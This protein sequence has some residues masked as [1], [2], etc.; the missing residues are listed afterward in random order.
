[1]SKGTRFLAWGLGGLLLAGIAFGLLQPAEPEPEFPGGVLG[2]SHHTLAQWI[3]LAT[4]GATP[5][6][7]T[8]EAEVAV[9]AA[10]TNA[11]PTLLK[12]TRY[13]P[14]P[15]KKFCYGI[16]SPLPLPEQIRQSLWRPMAQEMVLEY[17]ADTGFRL[18][19]SNAVPAIAELARLGADPL[20]TQVA[21]RA[22]HALGR[23]GPLAI[24]ELLRIIN[25]PNA[26]THAQAIQELAQFAADV[27]SIVP[28][29]LAFAQDPKADLSYPAVFMLRKIAVNPDAAVPA[30]AVALGSSDPL[31]RAAAADSLAHFGPEASQAVP[32][33]QF[34][35]LDKTCRVRESATNALRRIA[36]EA[37]PHAPMQ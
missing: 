19:N 36:P 3:D 1:M 16:L 14:N 9:R 31:T 37:L 17:W 26:R 35:L 24:P 21:A 5:R 15:L 28:F 4:K 10:G 33:L 7:A 6:Y 13:R 30:L 27:P 11:L 18:L 29:V 8:E 20:H 2:L 12:W 25:N 32:R 34:N 23:I 22:V